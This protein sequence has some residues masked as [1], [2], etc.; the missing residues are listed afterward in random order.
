MK[1]IL[2][3]LS[4]VTF[5]GSSTLAVSA[6]GVSQGTKVE[7]VIKDAP[8]KAE[9]NQDPLTDYVYNNQYTYIAN[10]VSYFLA[11]AA[12]LASDKIYEIKQ[13]GDGWEDFYNS[14]AWRRNA[15]TSF[16]YEPT[17]SGEA[18][19]FSYRAQGGEFIVQIN[20]GDA[21]LDD[22]LIRTYW[23]ITSANAGESPSSNNIIIPEIDDPEWEDQ[24]TITRT[25]WVHLYLVLED[26]KIDFDAEI[27]FNFSKTRDKSGQSVVILNLTTFS[28]PFGK[29][30]FENPPYEKIA[31]LAVSDYVPPET[32][33]S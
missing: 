13:T 14:N 2:A 9:N 3:F 4:A 15:F 1:K 17:L 24:N 19:A 32:P 25:G 6:C 8:T 30:D 12:Q 11:L 21:S 22:N 26:F 5:L 31:G 10:N 20:N 7:V 23:F 16:H 18:K 27:N 28:Q 33:E 29:I